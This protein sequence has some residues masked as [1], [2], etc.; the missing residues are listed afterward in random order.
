M[1]VENITVSQSELNAGSTT[2]TISGVILTSD[3]TKSYYRVSSLEVVNNS[4]KLV[5]YVPMT[6]REYTD[7]LLTPGIS[8][9]IQVSNGSTSTI[10]NPNGELTKIICSG[11]TGHTS[12]IV[13]TVIKEH[14]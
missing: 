4:G 9:F 6:T 5:H 2:K 3:A 13:F 12:G 8:G 1:L 14:W 7:W 10:N 11:V